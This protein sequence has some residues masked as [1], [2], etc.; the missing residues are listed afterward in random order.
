MLLSQQVIGK[1]L[2]E[3]RLLFHLRAHLDSQV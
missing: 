1:P 2:R 3:R